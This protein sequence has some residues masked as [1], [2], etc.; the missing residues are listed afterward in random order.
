ME[1][2]LISWI[3]IFVGCLLQG[4]GAGHFFLVDFIDFLEVV[5]NPLCFI[6]VRALPILTNSCWF[7]FGWGFLGLEKFNFSVCFWGGWIKIF[8]VI[9]SSSTKFILGVFS[10]C[11]VGGDSGHLFLFGVRGCSGCLKLL[12]KLLGVILIFFGHV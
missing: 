8:W 4:G 10:I 2:V 9:F 5:A 3:L 6:R 1:F 12:G 7:N 11:V